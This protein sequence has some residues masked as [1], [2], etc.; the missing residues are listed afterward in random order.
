MSRKLEN[1]THCCCWSVAV[2][3]EVIPLKGV[4]NGEETGEQ[5]VVI[6]NYRVP[7]TFTT[8]IEPQMVSCPDSRYTADRDFRIHPP[9]HLETT[10][11]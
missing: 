10:T 2:V 4:R 9:I 7:V 1:K 5:T 8:K 6:N 11:L 3:V